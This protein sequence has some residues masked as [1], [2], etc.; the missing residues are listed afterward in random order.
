MN[1]V[2][3]RVMPGA[4]FLVMVALIGVMQRRFNSEE[5]LTLPP[6]L[7][8]GRAVSGAATARRPLRN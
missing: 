3:S 5:L 8:A 2:V 6:Q 1:V 4:F 7:Q